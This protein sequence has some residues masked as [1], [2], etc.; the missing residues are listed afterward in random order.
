[1]SSLNG[2]NLFGSG[3]HTFTVGGRA[4]RHAT[5]D[6]PGAD[7]QQVTTLGRTARQFEQT[8]TLTAD[9][10]DALTQQLDAIEEALGEPPAVLTDDFGR[11]WDDVILTTFRPQRVRRV[12]LRLAVDYRAFYEQV[13]V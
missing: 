1:M 11:Q 7:G 6:Q 2:S 10:L 9:D 3:P 4:L 5:H 8:G 13:N 12:G